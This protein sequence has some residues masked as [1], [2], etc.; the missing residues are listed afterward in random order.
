[1]NR[2]IAVWGL[3]GIAILGSARGTLPTPA[4]IR[5]FESAVMQLTNEARA[6]Y[7]LA[8][9]RRN[10]NLDQSST[11]LAQDMAEHG[12]LEHTDR[13]GRSVGKRVTAFGYIEWRRVG[14]NIAAGCLTPQEV[15]TGWMNSPGHRAN[16]LSPEFTEIGIAYTVNPNDKFRHYWVQDF[17]KR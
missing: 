7:G 13:I 4:E 6:N 11:W 16:I 9:L 3:L 2:T 17:G 8:P 10:A 1:M 14:E 15:V 5:A 12:Y